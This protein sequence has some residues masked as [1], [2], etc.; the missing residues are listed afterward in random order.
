MDPLERLTNERRI[1]YGI[2]NT[3]VV[4][5]R[6]GNVWQFRYCII[7]RP[8]NVWSRP[9]EANMHYLAIIAFLYFFSSETR[10]IKRV[11]TQTFSSKRHFVSATVTSQAT[12]LDIA[13][14]KLCVRCHKAYLIMKPLSAWQVSWN[15]SPS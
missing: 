8:S 1:K 15:S 3:A 4:V 2:S 6:L 11:N 7:V 5:L 10:V 14:R 12:N 9:F 13:V